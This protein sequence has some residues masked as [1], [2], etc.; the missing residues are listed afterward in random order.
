M[1]Y[2]DSALT[3]AAPLLTVTGSTGRDLRYGVDFATV[4]LTSYSFTVTVGSGII[5]GTKFGGYSV[6][7]VT[8]SPAAD[9]PQ[10]DGVFTFTQ[11]GG[12]S[13]GD[14]VTVGQSW[15]VTITQSAYSGSGSSI[16]FQIGED[17]GLGGAVIRG[18]C[19]IEITPATSPQ[20]ASWDYYTPYDSPTPSTG[21]VTSAAAA[22]LPTITNAG[23][24]DPIEYPPD[25]YLTAL[26]LR[27]NGSFT[28]G[29]SAPVIEAFDYDDPTGDWVMTFGNAH[30]V[31]GGSPPPDPT[32]DPASSVWALFAYSGDY[33]PSIDPVRFAG[34]LVPVPYQ[35]WPSGDPLPA[36]DR[37][38][39]PELTRPF[40]FT[41][42]LLVSYVPPSGGW[43]LGLR[44]G[45]G[46]GWHV[47]G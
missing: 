11:S 5:A 30:L 9:L 24:G 26:Q 19:T 21:S 36:I 41:L 29:A 42:N 1:A 17:I 47:T 35:E 10:T 14:T 2:H 15:T 27:P 39:N 33:S 38:A 16:T 20:Q 18:R 4:G 44:I 43:T 22:N 25:P 8:P 45:G 12:P 7:N 46:A 32:T 3:L 6:G 34:T 13:T 23:V 28:T 37:T 31:A 40:D